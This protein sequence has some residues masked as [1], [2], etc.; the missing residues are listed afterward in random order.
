VHAPLG[1]RT[2][3]AEW[4]GAGSRAGD[5]IALALAAV[6]LAAGLRAVVAVTVGGP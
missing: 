5:A 2:V 4:R 6:L 1:L 3:I